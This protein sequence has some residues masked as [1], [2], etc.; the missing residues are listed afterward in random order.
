M[1]R[2]RPFRP[3]ALVLEPRLV[4][5]HAAPAPVAPAYAASGDYADSYRQA[6]HAYYLSEVA[7]GSAPVLFLGDSIT[8]LWNSETG[9]PQGEAAWESTFAPIGAENFGV[10]GD[11]TQNLLYRIEN[12]ELAGKPKVAVVLI[13]LNDLLLGSKKPAAVATGINDVVQQIRRSSPDTHILL[14]GLLPT[15]NGPAFASLENQVNAKI[16]PLGR[17][18][19]ITYLNPG[20]DFLQADG[21]LV[22]G[23][24]KD[25]I[26]PSATGYQ[27]LAEQLIG[28]VKAALRH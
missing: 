14:L 1:K 19:N 22:P 23:V 8:L 16:A 7:K 21:S 20:K 3:S 18:K 27:I 5:S 26:H 17:Q 11:Q 4:M 2:R 25:G 6:Y 12:G 24:L 9:N 10:L 15:A 13:G 28:P